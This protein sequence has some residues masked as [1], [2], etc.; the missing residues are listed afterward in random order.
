[1]PEVDEES[2]YNPGRACDAANGMGEHD[3]DENT[4]DTKEAEYADDG[5]QAYLPVLTPDFDVERH[6]KWARRPGV[7]ETQHEQ[8]DEYEHI[9]GRCSE[10]IHIGKHIVGVW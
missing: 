5:Q 1:M 9:S 3:E 7:L 10:S 6:L 8:R 2:Q 4:A